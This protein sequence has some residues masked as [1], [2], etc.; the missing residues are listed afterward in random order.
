MRTRE[1]ILVIERVMQKSVPDR[2]V[3][4]T[5][6]VTELCKFIEEARCD[7]QR[8]DKGRRQYSSMNGGMDNIF[9]DIFNMG[10]KRR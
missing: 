4:V 2:E 1:N 7:E 6:T 5:V 8:K 9:E 10:V 3:K